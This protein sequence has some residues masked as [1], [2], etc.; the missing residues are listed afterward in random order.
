MKAKPIDE[1]WEI[2][3]SMRKLVDANRKRP[4]VK[5]GEKGVKEVG[6]LR[7]LL[8]KYSKETKGK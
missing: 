6:L 2:A 7:E 8:L 4:K 3:K 5:I 1:E